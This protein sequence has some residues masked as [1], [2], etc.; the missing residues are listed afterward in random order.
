MPLWLG[1]LLS[2]HHHHHFFFSSLIFCFFTFFKSQKETKDRRLIFFF[3]LLVFCF[4]T[5]FINR[6]KPA[7]TPRVPAPCISFHV[8]SI[9]ADLFFSRSSPPNF[10]SLVEIYDSF[11][12]SR[13]AREIRNYN[14]SNPR[15]KARLAKLCHTR[16]L[17]KDFQSVKHIL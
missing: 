8:T 15:C 3:F 12:C 4:F 9:F 5:F 10:A 6:G 7:F 11:D 14:R 2:L 13:L 1:S 17:L 16:H